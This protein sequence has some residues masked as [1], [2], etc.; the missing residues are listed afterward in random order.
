MFAILVNKYNKYMQLHVHMLWDIKTHQFFYH[1]FLYLT[2]FDK[3]W[4]ALS[5]INEPQSTIKYSNFT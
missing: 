3:N 2:D 4:Y 1:N 5:L